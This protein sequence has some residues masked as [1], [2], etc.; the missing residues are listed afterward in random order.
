MRAKT[1]P[2]LESQVAFAFSTLADLN[3]DGELDWC[4]PS[5]SGMAVVLGN[6]S[7]AVTLQTIQGACAQAIAFSPVRGFS[8]L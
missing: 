5:S 2:D 8:Q 6:A 7:G 1:L 4:G 3:G